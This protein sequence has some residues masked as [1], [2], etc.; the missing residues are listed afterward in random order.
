M[1]VISTKVKP[2]FSVYNMVFQWDIH[3]QFLPC[4]VRSLNVVAC[5]LSGE[6][7]GLFSIQSSFSTISSLFSSSLHIF[8]WVVVGKCVWVYLSLK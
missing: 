5:R 4:V 3:E 1:C 6:F 7:V 8:R 2:V